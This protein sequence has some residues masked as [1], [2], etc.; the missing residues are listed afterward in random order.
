ML[1]LI[2]DSSVIISSYAE[3]RPG[4]N[5]QYRKYSE[6]C[7]RERNQH[8]VQ[9]AKCLLY[10]VE[11]YVVKSA[12]AAKLEQLYMQLIEELRRRHVP[13]AA[14][15][16]VAI[17]WGAT[18]ILVFLTDRLPFFPEW[19]G[20]VI[21]ILFVLG[22]PVAMFL[23]WRFDFSSKGLHRTTASGTSGLVTL[24]LSLL[25]LVTATAGLS[26]LLIPLTKQQSTTS[27]EYR[28]SK[29]AD[30]DAPQNSVAVLPFDNLGDDSEVKHFADGVTEEI[31]NALAR[32]EELLVIGRTSAFSF[33]GEDLEIG[34]IANRLGV[35]H[36]VE[37]SVR[38]SG[39]QLRVTAKLVEASSGFQ[40]WSENFDGTISDVFKFQDSI[41]SGVA[42]ALGETLG[43]SGL[44]G[45]ATAIKRSKNAEI[46]DKYLLARQVWRQRQE[47]PIRRS[48][49]LLEEVVAEDPGFSA[50][51]SALAA[52]NLTLGS[53][54][55]ESGD[56]G[57][58]AM[59]A[60]QQALALDETESEAHAVLAAVALWSGNWLEAAVRH[61]RARELAPNNSTVR[62]WYSEMLIKLGMV[63][64]ALQEVGVALS[65]DPMY[66]PALG[67][68][69]HQMAT[70]GR[71]NEAS[72]LFQR[73]WDLGL[74]A[75][76][77]WFGSYYVAL[78]QDRYGDA[79]LWLDRRPIPYGIEI[80]HALLAARQEPIEANLMRLT[81]KTLQGMEQGLALREAVLY[82]S[83]AEE[84]NLLYERL[85]PAARSGWRA[86]ESLWSVWARPLRQD[87]RFNELA[88][89]LGMLNY[90]QVYGP[91][92]ACEFTEGT[93]RCNR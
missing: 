48:I 51:W 19:T 38:R 92:D 10:A 2:S 66:T 85:L 49:A 67:N 26:Y 3:C 77:V 53:Y 71:L 64:R 24:M 61:E 20:T 28:G 50:G 44:G 6:N 70:A 25:I 63:E 81:E 30:V 23:A 47:G 88:Q 83:V 65:V 79:D 80:D 40:R 78:M 35:S 14:A 69:G 18:E 90:W 37:G 56:A 22:F 43:V 9:R 57:Q 86:T 21:A 45:R 12:N 16:Y 84:L 29:G 5:F 42:N 11:I 33:E 76:F 31:I 82:L 58:R 89:E 41:A 72:E 39:K 27:V 59:M 74:E 15:L 91:P 68:A 62:L 8:C 75:M 17:A 54:T 60:A 55:N 34:Q 87:P 36:V 1:L 32:V 73:A 7:S 13:R 52:A 93:I 4:N 46:Y